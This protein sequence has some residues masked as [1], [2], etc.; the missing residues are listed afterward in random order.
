M[1][2]GPLAAS[3]TGW[4]AD[5]RDYAKFGPTWTDYLGRK[6]PV[7]VS[8][9]RLKFKYPAHAALREHVFHRDGFKCVRC[10]AKAIDVPN[11]YTGRMTLQTDSFT[12]T[13]YRDVLVVDHVLTLKAGGKNC[14]TNYQTFCE[15]CNRRKIR[16]D[17]AA[18][19]SIK[20]AF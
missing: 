15:T 11:P 6:W 18:T 3:Y 5:M 20:D 13:G 16:E 1:G 4:C 10:S 12:G 7:I 8:G 9:R 17:V 14:V 2:M 19:A